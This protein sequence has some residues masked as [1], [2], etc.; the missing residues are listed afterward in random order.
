MKLFTSPLHY[1]YYWRIS[2]NQQLFSLSSRSLFVQRITALNNQFLYYSVLTP[3]SHS[4]ERKMYRGPYSTRNHYLL[5]LRLCRLFSPIILHRSS[6][7]LW[8][9]AVEDA[10]D[11]WGTGEQKRGQRGQLRMI[12][13]MWLIS[14]VANFPEYQT[15][16][17]EIEQ[18]QRTNQLHY[19]EI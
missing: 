18:V 13:E 16:I 17:R 15:A 1:Q 9:Q 14:N 8:P 2:R 5:Q 12:V 4:A 7:G 11:R 6:K 19:L 10:V 3:S